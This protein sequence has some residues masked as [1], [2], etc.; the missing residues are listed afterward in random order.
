MASSTCSAGQCS[1]LFHSP[2]TLTSCF[3][4]AS[5]TPHSQNSLESYPFFNS[6]QLIS[7]EI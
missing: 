3:P 7:R 1:S 6:E 2:F 4:K 5:D